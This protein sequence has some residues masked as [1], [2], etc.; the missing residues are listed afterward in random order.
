LEA[1]LHEMLICILQRLG[2]RVIPQA[3]KKELGV[4][5]KIAP[6]CSKEVLRQQDRGDDEGVFPPV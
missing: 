1:L 5:I 3:I 4:F 6:R 2:G